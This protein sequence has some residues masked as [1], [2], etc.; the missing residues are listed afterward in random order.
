M[1]FPAFMF[2]CVLTGTGKVTGSS[3]A[4]FVIGSIFFLIGLAGF[5]WGIRVLMGVKPAKTP[6]SNGLPAAADKADLRPNGYYRLSPEYTTRGQFLGLFLAAIFWNGITWGV[7]GTR[8]LK[9]TGPPL[10]FFS[11]FAIV[12]LLILWGAIYKFFTWTMVGDTTLEV[13]SSTL[14]P[15]QKLDVVIS[16]PGRFIINTLALDLVCREKAT[17]RA[18]TDTTT[19]TEIVREVPLIN[20]TNLS[21]REGKVLTQ[22][23]ITIPHDATM[24][25]DSTNNKVDWLVRIKMTIPRRPDSEQLFRLRILSPEVIAQEGRNNVRS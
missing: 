13:S 20:L 25:F 9:G 10:W 3:T 16:Q 11:I 19:R 23:S 5:I 4:I 1:A 18:G 15:G 22:Q 24:T 2:Y 17:Y 21:A 8:C 12:G 6:A 14:S 7:M